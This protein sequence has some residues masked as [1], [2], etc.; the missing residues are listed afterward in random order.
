MPQPEVQE[1]QEVGVPTTAPASPSSEPPQT[2]FL[3]GQDKDLLSGLPA[4][5]R[6]ERIQSLLAQWLR[7]ENVVVLMGAGVSVAHGGPLLGVLERDVLTAALDLVRADTTLATCAPILERRLSAIHDDSSSYHFERWLSFLSNAQYIASQADSPLAG[8]SLLG[9]AAAGAPPTS[10]AVDADALGRLIGLLSR[11]IYLRCS[12]RLPSLAEPGGPTAHHAFFAKLVARDAALGRTNIF[13]TNYDTLVEQALGDLGIHCFDGFTGTTS[14][15]FDPTSYGLDLYFP[16]DVRE[17]RVRRFDKVVHYYKTHGS[18]AWRRTADGNIVQAADPRASLWEP[19]QSADVTE[20]RGYLDQHISEAA[21]PIGILP[22][23]NKFVQTLGMPYAHLFRSLYMKLHEPQTFFLVIGYSFG[24]THINRLIDQALTN[25][26]LVLLVV[27][28]VGSD[29]LQS[30]IRRYQQS[31]ER[32]FLLRGQNA[33]GNA[34]QHATFSDFATTLM[35]QVQWLDDYVR[36]RK[37]EQTVR[38][39]GT[40]VDAGP[41]S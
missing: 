37:I 39:S 2:H 17:G 24:D 28:P 22:T 26:S 23:E 18:V 38:E 8:L 16:G 13:T 41:G 30:R 9:G 31:G 4:R 14:R 5:Q 21:G 29:V 36:L 1:E 25:P 11:L 19:F 40:D 32:A 10:L 15:H 6:V 33:A 27:D 20:R 35:P 12:L 7:M 34:P 3:H